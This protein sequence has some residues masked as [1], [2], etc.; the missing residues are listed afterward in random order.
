MASQQDKTTAR[1]EQEFFESVRPSS[2][3]KRFAS[4]EEVAAM[5]AFLASPRSAATNGAAVRVEG[6]VVRSIL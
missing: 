5:V 1:V 6:G 2:L 4:I 3:I